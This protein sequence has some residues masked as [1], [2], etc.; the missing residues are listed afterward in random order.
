MLWDEVYLA[1]EASKSTW[2]VEFG[3]LFSTTVT[4]VII[5]FTFHCAVINFVNHPWREPG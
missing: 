1:V 3:A 4:S 2:L 5:G